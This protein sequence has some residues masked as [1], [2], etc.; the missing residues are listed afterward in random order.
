MAQDRTL[1]NL[2]D[3][4]K[5]IDAMK[6]GDAVAASEIIRDHIK[7]FNDKMLEKTRKNPKA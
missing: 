3:F 6:A 1:E 2:M 7:R 4:K 5:I